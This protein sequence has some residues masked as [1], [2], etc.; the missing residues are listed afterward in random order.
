MEDK[1]NT[2]DFI[3][4]TADLNFYEFQS[5]LKEIT[6]T[7]KNKIYEDIKQDKSYLYG[8]MNRFDEAN[9]SELS[10]NG[11][12]IYRNFLDSNNPYICRLQ[13]HLERYAFPFGNDYNPLINTKLLRSKFLG[14]P[15][16]SYEVL[17]DITKKTNILDNYYDNNFDISGLRCR[18]T[19]IWPCKINSNGW[20]LDVTYDQLKIIIFLDDVDYS[21]G[22]MYYA[23][24]TH[25]WNNNIITSD[26]LEHKYNLFI[27]GP[28]KRLKFGD[29]VGNYK[30]AKMSQG[31]SI[32]YLP[33]NAVNHC[34]TLI[35][36][37][38]VSIFEK[39]YPKTVCVGKPGDIVIFES[40][41]LHSANICTKR[42]R[43]LAILSFPKAMSK[44][45]LFL[46]EVRGTLV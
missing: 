15:K 24:H 4:K 11:I 35:G 5:K 42:T 46:T 37:G 31:S 16:G 28:S 2:F 13:N 43:K 8:I 33:D 26:V 34:P 29:R 17:H 9:K 30:Q 10:E 45:N 38:N 7:H 20:H 21:T 18:Q 36:E 12:V 40:S 23:N 14:L 3:E 19:I 39:S 41:G 6:P 22:P 1:Q 25:L 44:K 32:C 27:G